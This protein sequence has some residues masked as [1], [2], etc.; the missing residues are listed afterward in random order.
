MCSFQKLP[1]PYRFAFQQGSAHHLPGQ[2]L[3]AEVDWFTQIFTL[4]FWL[5]YALPPLVVLPALLGEVVQQSEGYT[6]FL[7]AINRQSLGE[8]ALMLSL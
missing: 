7:K 2:F 3:P 5:I 8:N 1:D 6:R 4:P